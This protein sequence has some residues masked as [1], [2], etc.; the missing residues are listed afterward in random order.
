MMKIPTLAVVLDILSKPR[1][2]C[3]KAVAQKRYSFDEN[4]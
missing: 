1:K 4:N 3:K 2:Q